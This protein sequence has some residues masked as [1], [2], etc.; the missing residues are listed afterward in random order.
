MFERGQTCLEL[1]CGWIINVSANDGCRL[2]D[3]MICRTE[4]NQGIIFYIVVPTI[5]GPFLLCLVCNDAGVI[6]RQEAMVAFG[7]S[8]SEQCW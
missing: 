1:A 2:E 3:L 5:D 4:F 7:P 8:E 6:K